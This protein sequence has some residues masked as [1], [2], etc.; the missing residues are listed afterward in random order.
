MSLNPAQDKS[1]FF[2]IRS[3][4]AKYE[5]SPELMLGVFEEELR[6]AY[7]VLRAAAEQYQRDRFLIDAVAYYGV[8][9]R[10]AEVLGEQEWRVQMLHG[11]GV[12]NLE[13]K[14]YKESI[15]SL[16]LALEVARNAGLLEVEQIVQVD[17]D[18]ARL[19]WRKYQEHL[20]SGP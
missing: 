2:R 16:R 14:D 19:Q 4:L 1:I 12:V 8:L 5:E 7:P 17:L 10:I 3:E 20:D 18:A 15:A 13:L 11:Y 6:E 9:V